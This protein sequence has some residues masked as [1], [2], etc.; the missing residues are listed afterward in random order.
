[1]KPLTFLLLMLLSTLSSAQSTA[2]IE[3]NPLIKGTL[4]SPSGNVTKGNLII[5][6]AGSGPTNR[7]GNQIGNI[8]NSLKFLAEGLAGKGNY[9]FSYDKRIIAQIIA[10]N[11]DE[12]SLRFSHFID[13]AKDVIAYF[14]KTNKYD[15]IIVAGHSEGSLIGMVAAKDNADAFISL[16]GAGRTIDQV[17]VDQITW[18]FPNLHGEAIATFDQL[19]K[20]ETIQTKNPVLLSF[21][22][23]DVQPYLL[24]WVAIDPQ[25]EIKKLNVPVLIVNGTKDIQVKVSEAEF[26]KAAK[27]N[28]QYHIIDNMNHIFKEVKGDDAENKATYNNATLPVM[29]KVIDIINDFVKAL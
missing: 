25:Q 14:K 1:M 4:F 22:R 5:L 2:D 29:P 27:P 11:A 7:S 16:A 3:I 19:K 6:I 8:N 9:V 21:L 28:A 24:S 20:G 23:P 13:D 15:K 17:I 26:L 10:G 12:K 18:Q